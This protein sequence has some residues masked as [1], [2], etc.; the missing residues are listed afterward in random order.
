M[1]MKQNNIPSNNYEINK[2]KSEEYQDWLSK[3]LPKHNGLIIQFMTSKKYQ[4]SLGESVQ[5]IEVKYDMKLAKTNNLFI[6][7]YEKR[8]HENHTFIESGILRKDNTIIYGIGDYKILYL[9]S[10]KLLLHIY[11]KYQNMNNS[12]LSNNNWVI[13][14]KEGKPIMSASKTSI[15]FLLNTENM[16]DWIYIDKVIFSC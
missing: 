12:F 6:E 16:P 8:R 7:I 10:K 9:F 13:F 3:E 1:E 2:N 4:Y 14:E 15:G 11:S 5:G